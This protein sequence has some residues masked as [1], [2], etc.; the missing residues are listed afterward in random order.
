[1]GAEDHD[2]ALG[3]LT[4]IVHEDHAP[5]DEAINDMLV[6][7]NLVVDIDRFVLADDV[8]HLIDDIDGHAYAGTESTRVGEHD[9]HRAIV[10][11]VGYT[12]SRNLDNTARGRPR[13]GTGLGA[14]QRQMRI[15]A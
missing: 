13:L 7:H 3:D 2:A 8:Q 12:G 14:A 11:S 1:M 10:V 5:I 15:I 4:Q 9:L 6:V